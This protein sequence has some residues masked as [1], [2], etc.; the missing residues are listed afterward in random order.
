MD[1]RFAEMCDRIFS[2]AA[3]IGPR[4][5]HVVGNAQ[6]PEVWLFAVGLIGCFTWH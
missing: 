3:T 4:V 5:A 1:G 6:H 2:D